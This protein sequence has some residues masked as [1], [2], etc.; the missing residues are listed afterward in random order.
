MDD[1]NTYGRAADTMPAG[2]RPAV[3]DEGPP[4]VYAPR[5]T[6]MAGSLNGRGGAV[7]DDGLAPLQGLSIGAAWHDGVSLARQCVREHPLASV[8]VGLLVGVVLGRR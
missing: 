2:D 7:L 8:A 4:P 3:A 5:E 6:P 1:T